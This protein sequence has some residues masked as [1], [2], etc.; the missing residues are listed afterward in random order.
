MSFKNQVCLESWNF[1]RLFIRLKDDV[2]PDNDDDQQ[3]YPK[4]TAGNPEIAAREVSR[5]LPDHAPNQRHGH[6][7]VVPRPQSRKFHN[8]SIRWL[9]L[10]G[11]PD[12]LL[13]RRPDSEPNVECHY[14]SE[15]RS[16]V[17]ESS[18]IAELTEVH[19]E[20]DNNGEHHERNNHS[21][22]H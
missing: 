4:V 19:E 2:P 1:S 22:A 10:L 11:C 15:Q 6:V 17:N 21:G 20:N 3:K 18:T 13:L 16:G 9:A 8:F 14:R 7:R 12:D 5:V